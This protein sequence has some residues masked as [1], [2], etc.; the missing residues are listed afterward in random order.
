MLEAAVQVARAQGLAALTFGAVARHLGTN[1][2]TVVYY[3]PTKADLIEAVLITLGEELQG[4]LSEAFGDRP[5]PPKDLARRA[6]PVLARAEGVFA[7]FFEIIGLA[8]V[9]REPYDV[10]AP[11]MLEQWLA[12]LEPRIAVDDP[13]QRRAHALGILAQ[14]DGLLLLR[15]ISGTDAAEAAAKVSGLR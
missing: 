12:W 3:F 14:L 6:W 8:A 13:A 11:A 15:T 5:I 7:L 9:G 2:R 1:D 10:L 4:L